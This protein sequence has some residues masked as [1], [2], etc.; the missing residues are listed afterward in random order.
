MKKIG[1][2]LCLL[3]LFAASFVRA[4]QAHINEDWD[5]QK[6]KENLVPFSAN[7]ISPEVMDDRTVIFR[8]R[9][10]EVKSVTLSGSMFVGPGAPRSVPF[11][12][13]ED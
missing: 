5:P 6:N 8:L 10:P 9:G 4:Q 13:G 1:I 2:V 7:V 12:K 3:F 11:V